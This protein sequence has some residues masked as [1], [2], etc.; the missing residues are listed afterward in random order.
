MNKPNN[1]ANTQR[2]TAD[3]FN[4]L[5]AG[6]YIIKIMEVLEGQ[7]KTG[8][9]MLTVS[10]D[11]AE[12]EQKDFF[13]NAYKADT[14]EEKKWGGRHWIVTEDNEGNCSRGFKSFTECVENSNPGF[15]IPWGEGFCKAMKGKLVG[16]MFRD[17]EYITNKGEYR[18]SA[19]IAYWATVDEVRE[20]KLSE[21]AP[22]YCDHSQKTTEEIQKQIDADLDLEDLPF[23]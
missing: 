2:A 17:E 18:M 7:S 9:P 15:T 13:T 12:G 1:Y 21:L 5:P 3:G 10:Y 14:R 16:A 6:N 20:G 4:R 22:K 23:K 19:K 8:K 11:I